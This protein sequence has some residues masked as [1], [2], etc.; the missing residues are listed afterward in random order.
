MTFVLCQF[1]NESHSFWASNPAGRGNG[2]VGWGGGPEGFSF[3]ADG[4][5]QDVFVP[6]SL[7]EVN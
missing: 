1:F 5:T 7:W 4:R 6:A 2:G 3:Q